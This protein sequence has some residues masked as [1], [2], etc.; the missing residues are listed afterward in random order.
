MNE[1]LF[2]VVIVVLSPL[3]LLAWF[4]ILYLFLSKKKEANQ[5]L[6]II[7]IISLYLFSL[8][9]VGLFVGYYLMSKKVKTTDSPNYK[10]SEEVRSNGSLILIISIASTLFSLLNL[11]Q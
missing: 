11:A 2:I 1:N 8:V 9:P 3:L 10:Y 5:D 6:S 4:N 7:S